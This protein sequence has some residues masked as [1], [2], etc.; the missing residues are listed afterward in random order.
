MSRRKKADE[1]QE[2]EVDMT[3]M[4]DIVFILLIFF[5]VTTSFVKEEGLEINRPKAENNPNPPKTPVIGIKITDN[6]QVVFNN[7]LVDIER[8]PARIENFLANTPTTSAVII[9]EDNAV[10]E[11]VVAV[12]DQV[13]QF[14]ELTVSIGKAK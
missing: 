10:Y 5:I 2:S 7:K 3:P 6:G 13:K 4:L 12:I 11:D 14:N 1:I 8:L 9:P